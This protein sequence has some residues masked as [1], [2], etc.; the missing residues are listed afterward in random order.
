M[1]SSSLS[2]KPSRTNPRR[3]ARGDG[4]RI[5]VVMGVAG[6]GKTTIGRQLATD[7]GWPFFE[8]DD[9]HSAANRRKMSRGIPLDDDDRAPWLTALRTQIDVCL[10]TGR[11]AVLVCSALKEKYRQTLMKGTRGV[12]LVHLSGDLATIQARIAR[13]KGHFMKAGMLQGQFEI[14]EPPANALVLDVRNSPAAIIAEIKRQF[15]L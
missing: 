11:N 5:I 15:T 4:A 8:A 9:F 10:A 2:G 12:L 14:L 1:P 3:P 13:R 7:L 6:S